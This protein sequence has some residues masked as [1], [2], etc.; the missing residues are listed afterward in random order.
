MLFRSPD[1]GRAGIRARAELAR[2][3]LAGMQQIADAIANGATSKE[4]KARQPS[5]LALIRECVMRQPAEGYARSCEALAS[6]QAAAVE[7][8]DVPTLLITGDQDGVAPAA[9]V[10]AMGDRIRGSRV[11]VLEGCGHWTA[12]EK[13]TDCVHELGRFY[14]GLG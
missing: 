11:V 14:A 3:G 10:R 9:N 7:G 2:T 12:F 8:I 5:V 13:P 6:A 4:T 1:S